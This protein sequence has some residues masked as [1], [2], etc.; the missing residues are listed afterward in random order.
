MKKTLFYACLAI[1]AIACTKNDN[2]TTPQEDNFTAP[3][4]VYASID[5]QTRTELHWENQAPKTYW[6][7]GDKIAVFNQE[8]TYHAYQ[9]AGD[10]ITRNGE[11]NLIEN[12]EPTSVVDKDYF[13]FDE[14]IT[15]AFYPHSNSLQLIENKSDND[16]KY[17]IF[18][19]PRVQQ[20]SVDNSFGR[21][22]SPMLAIAENGSNDY[23]FKNIFGYLKITLKGEAIVK[24]IELSGNKNESIAGRFPIALEGDDIYNIIVDNDDNECFKSI[25]LDCGN[26]G[27][28]LNNDN[29]VSFLF[30]LPPT[31]FCNGFTIIVTDSNGLKYK[32]STAN[33][34]EITKN[35]I[36]VMEPLTP[37][38]ETWPVIL[39]EATSIIDE[40]DRTRILDASN[41]GLKGTVTYDE[42]TG[43]G[44]ISFDGII[45]KIGDYSIFSFNSK[46]LITS[47]TLPEGI[48]IIGNGSLYGLTELTTINIPESVVKID[49]TAF[50]GCKKLQSKI[51]IPEGCTHLGTTAFH[52]CE[53]LEEVTIN[54]KSLKIWDS[55]FGSCSKLKKV[56]FNS[57]EPPTLYTGANTTTTIDKIFDGCHKDLTIYVPE[58]SIETYK[59]NDAWRIYADK[60]QAIKEQ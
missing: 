47:L 51:I 17:L 16:K 7:V 34:I 31:E 21:E 30:T 5:G 55:A 12:S 50:S 58:E 52:G 44:T 11:F 1:I 57:N 60:I 24:A 36:K 20:F 56:T 45:S 37:V 13:T 41:K 14:G 46:T 18:T 43:K 4:T 28:Q 6:S 53:E 32:I 40:P 49:N 19:T 8:Y 29:G 15:Y 25:T 59:D 35:H 10:N 33:K 2:I 38:F 22:A 23:S 26:D 39:Y 42:S 27:V 54:S 9:L 48:R 3:N